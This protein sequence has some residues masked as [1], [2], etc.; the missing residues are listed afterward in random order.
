MRPLPRS[1][2]VGPLFLPPFSLFFL[3]S[4]VTLST[5]WLFI[6]KF[7]L[8]KN[9]NSSVPLVIFQVFSRHVWQLAT[10]WDIADTEHFLYHR[11]FYWKVLLSG[12]AH[13]LPLTLPW[14]VS[15]L[16]LCQI[17]FFFFFLFNRSA[18]SLS[19]PNI[20][21]AGVSQWKLQ[22]LKIVVQQTNTA[23]KSSQRKMHSLTSN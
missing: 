18:N 14:K 9:N 6:W 21:S 3:I 19:E 10:I 22:G 2:S 11:K 1:D 17:L 5:R 4:R 13:L 16:S 8:N 20:M 23:N 7:K 15:F 12:W